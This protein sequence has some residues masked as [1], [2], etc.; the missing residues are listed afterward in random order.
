MQTH[1]RIYIAGHRGLVGS[2]IH[3]CLT[4][5]GF[6]N[7]VT[8][9]SYDLDLR[10]KDATLSFM[11]DE[12]PEY[13]F[14]CAA[15]VGGIKANVDFPGDF[16]Y[17]NLMIQS[18]VIDAAMLTGVTKL[19]FLGSSCIYPRNASQPIH[20]SALLTGALE[21]T[22]KAYAIA[23]IAGIEMC[24]AY[25]KQFKL[26]SICVMPTNLYGPNDRFDDSGHVVPGLIRRFHDA[27][28]AHAPVVDVWG[29]GQARREFLHA[30]DAADAMVFLMRNYDG[31]G[32]VN[33]GCGKDVSIMDLAYDIE[34]ITGYLGSVRFD[35]GK[36]DGTP[37]KL[38]NCEKLFKMG[39]SPKICLAKGLRMTY[40]W[41]CANENLLHQ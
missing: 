17:D 4:A 9:T 36:P 23:K 38:L 3:R 10:D 8:R 20:E 27:K 5:D 1:S 16:I 14:L 24:Q 2:A 26:N 13:V 35:T 39:W 33:V 7:I 11:D 32:P 28:V 19:M 22:N 41:Y 34:R 15:K 25:R 21:A 30:D 6:T 18:N 40:D 31:E 29:S 12:R 37:R